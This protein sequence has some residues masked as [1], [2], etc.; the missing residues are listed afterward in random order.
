MY[1]GELLCQRCQTSMHRRGEG[2]SDAPGF[3][4]TCVY[5]GELLC[6][7]CQTSVHR[8]GEGPSDA[9]GFRATCVYVGELALPKESDIG[10]VLFICDWICK[11]GT[12]CTI[13]E[14]LFP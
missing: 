12:T 1:V 13:S 4:A 11:N 2:P 10:A 8:R 7:R 3:K 14:C 9:P 5:V 6:Q